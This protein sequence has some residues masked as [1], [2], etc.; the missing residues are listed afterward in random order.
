MRN[1]FLKFILYFLYFLTSAFVGSYLGLGLG[2]GISAG[3]YYLLSEAYSL[4]IAILINSGIVL[5]VKNILAVLPTCV[6]TCLGM[7]VSFRANLKVNEQKPPLGLDKFSP[8]TW[9]FITIWPTLILTG[10]IAIVCSL[11][12]GLM[13]TFPG[14]GTTRGVLLTWIGACIGMLMLLRAD[15]RIK[16]KAPPPL[17]LLYVDNPEPNSNYYLITWPVVKILGVF[18]IFITLIIGLIW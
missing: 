2:I 4:L 15:L 12:I 6:G 7:F 17:S 14:N 10:I 5:E 13:E 18:M 16:E 8:K 9:Y 3:I 1:T 11:Y